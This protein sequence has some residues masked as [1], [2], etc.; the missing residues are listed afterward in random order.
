MKLIQISHE[1]MWEKKESNPD[2]TILRITE[3]IE[4]LSLGK[5]SGTMY[6]TD[7]VTNENGK[8]E[9]LI[10]LTKAQLKEATLN[11]KEYLHIS[12]KKIEFV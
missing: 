3:R 2:F 11:T 10:G 1:K 12:T 5:F 8:P 4:V 6:F 7:T 9:K